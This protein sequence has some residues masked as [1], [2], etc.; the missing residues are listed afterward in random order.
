MTDR[1]LV[2][3]AAD[4]QQVRHAGRKEKDRRKAELDDVRAVLSTVE[5]RRLLWRLMGWSGYLENPSHQ[6]GDMT[7]QNIGR[8]DAGRFILAEI[9]DADEQ[10]YLLMQQ[11]SWRAKRSEAVEAE[12]VRT[13]SATQ[14]DA[15]QQ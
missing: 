15:Q 13:K 7:H 12:A 6:R 5:G 11:E 3:N 8:A 10:K 4:S 1:P 2:A 14:S 9:M